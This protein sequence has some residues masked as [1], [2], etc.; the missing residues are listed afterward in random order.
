YRPPPGRG[1]GP[2]RRPRRPPA[3][4]G[5]ADGG[6]HARGLSE[7]GRP[8]RA[9]GSGAH[10]AR[11]TSSRKGTDAMRESAQHYT[12]RLLGYTEGGE[13]LRLQQAAPRKLAALL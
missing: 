2:P 5:P 12:Q 1:A 3:L 8:R 13:P 4:H 7:W 10:R 11:L 9:G 6:A